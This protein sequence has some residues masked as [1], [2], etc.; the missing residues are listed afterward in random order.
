MNGCTDGR[1]RR[2]DT[3]TDGRTDRRTVVVIVAPTHR[4]TDGRTVVVVTPTHQRTDRQMDGR[5]SS[6]RHTDGR[7][8]VVIVA[9][10]RRRTDGR[11]RRGAD[12][13]PLRV[14]KIIVPHTFRGVM[15]VRLMQNDPL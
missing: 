9:P 13:P 3:P 7:T 10:T 5:S 15:E 14:N 1:Y 2:A 12:S 8:V 11:R 4:R 6:R